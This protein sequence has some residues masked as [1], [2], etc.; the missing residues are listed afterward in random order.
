[1][2]RPSRIEQ[3]LSQ[4]PCMSIRRPGPKA[5]GQSLCA[6]G[7]S[8]HF[9]NHL[10]MVYG[11]CLLRLGLSKVGAGSWSP[12]CHSWHVDRDDCVLQRF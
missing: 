3:G 11:C 7:G 1:M 12:P 9:Y 2:G 4:Q 10:V 5:C 6:G 8:L